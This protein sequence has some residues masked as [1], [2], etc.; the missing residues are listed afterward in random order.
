MIEKVMEENFIPL[1][2]G[3]SVEGREIRAYRS[4]QLADSY[5]Y[6]MSGVHGD[7]IEGIYV[8]EQLFKELTEIEK[9]SP[10]SMI[11]IPTANPDGWEK[12]TRT[13]ARGVDL[14]RNLPSRCWTSEVRSEQYYP[15]KAPMSE[16]ENIFLDGLFQ[17]FPPFFIISFHSWVP[18]IN[19]NGNCKAVAE[20]LGRY[21]NYPICNSI[22]GHPT[23]GSLGEYGP[24]KYNT[25]VLTLEFPRY[26]SGAT[27][28]TIWQES[29]VGL[30]KL[31]QSDLRKIL[32][33]T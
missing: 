12:K 25:P 8:L 10:N 15:G 29:G 17:K 28:E 32:S 4:R 27:P 20:F 22:E 19:Y 14:N 16:P 24:E 1:E 2:S 5:L 18:M 3:R 13:N 26:D 11:I 31:V 7:E 9:G 21:N 6:L 30:S 23:P 33:I